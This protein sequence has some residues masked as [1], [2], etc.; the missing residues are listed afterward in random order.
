M[1][2]IREKIE[3]S[4][5]KI[6]YASKKNKTYRTQIPKEISKY[7]EFEV[8][9]YFKWSY[10]TKLKRILI[11]I[12]TKD[13]ENVEINKNTS[14]NIDELTQK[15]QKKINEKKY[16]K[17]NKKEG[18][19]I[20]NE[21][22]QI[23]I[24]AYIKINDL[25]DD[26]NNM[27]NNKWNKKSIETSKLNVE[28]YITEES[29]PHIRNNPFYYCLTKDDYDK[30]RKDVYDET[31]FKNISYKD[32]QKIIQN[33]IHYEDLN[34]DSEE[35]TPKNKNDKIISTTTTNNNKYQ[36][37]LQNNPHKQIV[38]KSIERNK[39]VTNFSVTKR[40]EDEIKQII[41]EIKESNCNNE[42]EIK[43]FVQKYR[44]STK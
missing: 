32:L 28:Y 40:S 14:S 23:N 21:E 13:G 43:E 26:L 2:E 24:G 11:D 31:P 19:Y 42:D 25:K 10:D 3:F 36:I 35:P 39:Q 22:K 33:S 4:K 44:Q 12:I 16:I 38:I 15:Q 29:Y 17:G 20:V 34:D 18:Y 8:G 27:I 1:T 9:N 6:T 37:I 5:T 7:I 30:M 41:K